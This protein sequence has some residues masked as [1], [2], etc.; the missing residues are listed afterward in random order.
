MVQG[1]TGQDSEASLAATLRGT[2]T[3]ILTALRGRW[4]LEQRSNMSRFAFSSDF[5]GAMWRMAL[6]A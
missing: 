1:D 3:F 6:R 2:L 5:S 4:G